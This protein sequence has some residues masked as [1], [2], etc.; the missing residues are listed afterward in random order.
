VFSGYKKWFSRGLA[1]LLPTLITLFIIFSLI[2]FINDN[3]GRYI[4]IGLTQGAAWIWPE[5]GTPQPEA[6]EQSLKNR[7]IT[8]KSVGQEQYRRAFQNASQKIRDQRIET[9]SRSWAVGLLGFVVALFLVTLIGIL[10]ASIIGRQL[11]QSIEAMIIRI[12]VVRQ[13]YPYVK[14]VTDYI[15]GQKKLDFSRVVAIQYPSKGLWQMGFI[16]GPA[17]KAFQ[18]HDPQGREF[19][20]VFVPTSPTPF[21]GYVVV[22]VKEEVLDLPITIDQAFRFLLSGGVISPEM[23]LTSASS[24]NSSPGGGPPGS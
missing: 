1:A 22:V 15:F 24:G 11:W 4:G 2:S 7:Q 5:L 3:F 14:Q 10:L 18:S 21:T 17:M 13:I 23:V 8:P 20:S 9:L 19:V 6:V 12:P 16:T